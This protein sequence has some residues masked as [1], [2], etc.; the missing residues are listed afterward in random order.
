MVGSEAHGIRREAE[1]MVK[2]RISIPGAGKT[3]SLNAGVAAG[4]VMHSLF[5]QIK[6]I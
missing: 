1:M 2:K 5:G 6:L 3:E 4:I